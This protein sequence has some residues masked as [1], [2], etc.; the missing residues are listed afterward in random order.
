V[1]E[2]SS[3]VIAP[4]RAWANRLLRLPA[5]GTRL[6]PSEADGDTRPK[7][8]EG[9]RPSA[10]L[11]A[12]GGSSSLVKSSRTAPMLPRIPVSS[13]GKNT[14]VALPSAMRARASR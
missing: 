2:K 9:P 14:L 11:Y 7:A 13:I 8:A 4:G 1:A 12:V 6:T 3:G 5:C 10:S